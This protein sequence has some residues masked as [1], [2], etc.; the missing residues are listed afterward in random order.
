MKKYTSALALA[1]AVSMSL[2][3]APSWAAESMQSGDSPRQSM[4]Q[5]QAA[6]INPG[7][8]IGKV[9][10]THKGQT[11]GTIGSLVS[12]DNDQGVYALVDVSPDLG[13]GADRVVVPISQ[14]QPQ[15][16]QWEVP[17]DI[18]PAQVSNQMLYDP[19]QFSAFEAPEPSSSPQQQAAAPQQQPSV[20]ASPNRLNRSWCRLS[21]PSCSTPTSRT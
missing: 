2:A 17:S 9:I 15:G 5:S 1:A 7:D 12:K 21:A 16:N 13:L 14:L 20:E 6:A 8:Y 3:T 19:A 11:I 4:T 18:T 10:K